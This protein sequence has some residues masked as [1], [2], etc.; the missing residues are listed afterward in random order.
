MNPE[1]DHHEYQRFVRFPPTVFARCCNVKF[2]SIFSHY[3]SVMMET[4]I[5]VS[6]NGLQEGSKVIEE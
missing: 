5:L 2:N 6:E 3:S 4:T 1:H